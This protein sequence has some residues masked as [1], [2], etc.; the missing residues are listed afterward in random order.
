MKAGKEY[1]MNSKTKWKLWGSESETPLTEE[2]LSIHIF[3]VLKNMAKR[4]AATVQV[5]EIL[6]SINATYVITPAFEPCQLV[7]CLNESLNMISR[8]WYKKYT[9]SCKVQTSYECMVYVLEALNDMACEEYI[10]FYEFISNQSEQCTIHSLGEVSI[11]LE[12]IAA[13]IEFI[14]KF[15]FGSAFALVFMGRKQYYNEDALYENAEGGID[16]IKSD[17]QRILSYIL[18][19]KS[20]KDGRIVDCAIMHRDLGFGSDINEL[21]LPILFLLRPVGIQLENQGYCSFPILEGVKLIPD[22]AT[23]HFKINSQFANELNRV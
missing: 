4:E 6:D 19:A 8:A 14:W 10:D 11:C 13:F 20:G 7:Q 2:E 9:K 15:D 1:D 5:A 3:G 12:E 21:V 22:S 16:K 18:E 17:C 23:V